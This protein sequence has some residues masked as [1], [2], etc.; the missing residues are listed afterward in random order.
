M[1]RARMNEGQIAGPMSEAQTDAA[2]AYQRLSRPNVGQV[3]CP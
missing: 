2:H 1:G 3:W